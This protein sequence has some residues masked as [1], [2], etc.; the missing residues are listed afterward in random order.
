M[1]HPRPAILGAHPAIAGQKDALKSAG[2]EHWPAIGAHVVVKPDTCI[3]QVVAPD[4]LQA[5]GGHVPGH[6]HGQFPRK[7]LVLGQV[8]Q[9]TIRAP[10]VRRAQ[11]GAARLDEKAVPLL[12]RCH[13]LCRR[14]PFVEQRRL[15]Y[16]ATN[17][18]SLGQGHLQHLVEFRLMGGALHY[19]PTGSHRLVAVGDL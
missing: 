11:I 7:A 17:P 16:Q 13:P 9:P 10:Q 1:L 5:H 14:K 6:L 8:H 12:Q 4:R 2:G 3:V 18:R 15:E 19:T